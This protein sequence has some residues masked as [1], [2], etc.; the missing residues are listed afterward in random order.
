MLNL[1]TQMSRMTRRP[2]TRDRDLQRRLVVDLALAVSRCPDLTSATQLVLDRLCAET[3]WPYGEVWIPS[4]DGRHLQLAP[5]WSGARREF[6]RL[7]RESMTYRFRPGEG[8]P[9]RIWKSGRP[10]WLKSLARPRLFPR[11]PLARKLG[12]RSGF[13][14]PVLAGREVV[15]V[16]LFLDLAE[17][18]DNWVLSGVVRAVAALLGA[19]L[20]RRRAEDDL[21]RANESLERQ[22]L[23]R[24]RELRAVVETAPDAILTIDEEGRIESFN[25]A[26]ERLFGFP[27]AKA[28]GRN[29]SMLMPSPDRERHDGYLERYHRTGERRVIG[30]G[31]EATALR[32]DGTAFPVYLSIGEARLGD[33]R[34]YTG[35][36]RDLT[37]LKRMQEEVVRSQRLAAVGEMSAAVAHEIKNPLAAISGALQIL[38]DRAPAD[39]TRPVMDE[40]LRQVA[41]LDGTVRKLGQLARPWVPRK[42][43]CELA[44]LAERVARAAL[45]SPELAGVTVEVSPRSREAVAADA[46]LIEQVL[47]NLL[48]NAAQAMK[49]GKIGIDIGERNGSVVMSVSDSGPGLE[50]AV[51]ANLFK[52]FFTTKASGSGL[53][54]SICRS[55]MEAHGG[56][57]D[58]HSEPGRGTTVVLEFPKA[59]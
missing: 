21:R 4:E 30:L 8:L 37:E 22:I 3:G 24:T 2:R 48:L 28:I 41:R 43:S 14:V 53:G 19:P 47:W 20:L 29:V 7:H 9:G 59:R 45:N 36:L 13:G 18:H 6:A 58:L 42:E 50:P 11:A 10:R 33:R 51:L 17:W 25:P 27:A 56:R 1:T 23:E 16:L 26:A 38:R 15:A 34:I 57:I 49:E 31:R 5:V 35:I 40:V 44:G 12:L 46:G 55:I 52:P 54:L 39:E 32:A